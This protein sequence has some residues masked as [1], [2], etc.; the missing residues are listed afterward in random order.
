MEMFA[1]TVMSWAASIHFKKIKFW[2]GTACESCWKLLNIY[3][4]SK[5]SKILE[6]WPH[7]PRTQHIH[8]SPLAVLRRRS[9]TS[10]SDH[11]LEILLSKKSFGLFL[12]S[13]DS[14]LFSIQL[15]DCLMPN[16]NISSP[17]RECRLVVD[18]ALREI[19]REVTPSKWFSFTVEKTRLCFHEIMPREN[20]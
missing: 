6:T 16:C 9:M 19:S 7:A 1:I 4:N 17:L 12:A 10:P 13:R 3:S 18:L 20:K 2:R 8:K 11:F 5:S 14:L 15:G